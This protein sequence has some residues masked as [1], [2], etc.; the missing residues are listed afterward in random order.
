MATIS[1][2]D[3]L[4]K[5]MG[6]AA[7]VVK[8]VCGCAN[9]AAWMVVSEAMDHL[10]KSPRY[11]HQVKQAFKLATLELH[12]YETNLLTASTNR[13]FHL[14][15]MG[16]STRRK[17]GDISDREYYDFWKAIGSAAYTRTYPHITSLQNKYRLSLQHHGVRDADLVAWTM[18]AQAAI[19]LAI[20]LYDYA[21][22]ECIS[23]YAINRRL[24]EYV[25]DQFK[26]SKVSAKWYHA[27][28]VLAPET[29]DYDL[30]EV[31]KRNIE[32]GLAQLCEAWVQP[33]LL[34]S[35]TGDTV[36]EYDEVFAT[37]GFQKMAMREIADIE[38]E[39]LNE[40]EEDERRESANRKHAAAASGNS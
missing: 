37:P 19:D 13:M 22:K 17:Y 6:A 21:L 23:G 7:S 39:T 30:D 35:S 18:T 31:E 28:L 15:D 20:K 8:L 34:Y 5:R 40:L 11:R 1:R 10:K 29:A 9:N 25:F 36:A 2:S 32:H 14:A 38:K 12:R 26:L 24:L 33:S 27:M 16:E 4:G 3:E